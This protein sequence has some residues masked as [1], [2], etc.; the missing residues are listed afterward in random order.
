MKKIIILSIVIFAVVLI[1]V[2]LCAQEQ[3]PGQ[4]LVFPK[5]QVQE[6]PSDLHMGSDPYYQ[7]EKHK[8]KGSDE[9]GYPRE[10]DPNVEY[11]ESTTT[12]KRIDKKKLKETTEE[13]E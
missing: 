9:T 6:H 11:K 12:Y 8:Y 5:D 10:Y 1:G 3:K 13:T 2:F 4:P 7:K